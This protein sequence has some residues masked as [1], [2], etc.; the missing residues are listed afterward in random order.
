MIQDNLYWPITYPWG[1]VVYHIGKFLLIG[2]VDSPN[3]EL[4]YINYHRAHLAPKRKTL[5]RQICAMMKGW[6]K[7]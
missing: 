4:N 6:T 7:I 3:K 1:T 5:K 2:E